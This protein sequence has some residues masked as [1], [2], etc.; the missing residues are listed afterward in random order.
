[1]HQQAFPHQYLRSRQ[2][3]CALSYTCIYYTTEM[4]MCNAQIDN[5]DWMKNERSAKTSNKD[6]TLLYP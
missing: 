4:Q 1:M 3:P 2:E 6:R 5:F